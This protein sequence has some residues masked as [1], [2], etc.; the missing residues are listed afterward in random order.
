MNK[1]KKIVLFISEGISE[2]TSLSLILSKL[3]NNHSIKFKI[4]G[5]DITTRDDVTPSN[6]VNMITEEIK[7]F[8]EKEP[9]NKSDIIKVVHLIDT[10]GAFICD[11][12]IKL[13]DNNKI[14]YTQDEILTKD[15][16]YIVDIH[17]KKQSILNHLI[18]MPSIYNGVDYEI[19]Y[20][21]RNLEH[22]LHNRADCSRDEKNDLAEG[23]EDRF[24]DNP[25]KFI[26][27]LNNNDFAVNYGYKETWD[28]IKK[29][30]NSLKRYTNFN[31]FINNL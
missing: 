5:T 3:I 9:Y 29:D 16:E 8:L 10:D 28:F 2:E 18:S 14:I 24:F 21:S 22:V 1:E 12:N 13:S 30:N 19:Y 27:F 15:V 17:K 26:S 11:E 7:F 6:I 23:F 4:I 31:I 20:F 25:K